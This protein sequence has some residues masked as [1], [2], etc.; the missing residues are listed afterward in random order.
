MPSR[1]ST[2]GSDKQKVQAYFAKLPVSARLRLRELQRAIRAAAPK[3]VIAFSY[4]IPAYRL[5][6]RLLVWYAAFAHHCSLFP[7]TPAIRRQF[8]KELTGYKV[9]KGTVRFPLDTPIPAGLVRRLVK[10]RMAA[11]GPQ[12]RARLNGRGHP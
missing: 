6:G 3:G 7:M 8:A 2:K 12:R 10:A 1:V 11:L 9:A 4:Q 5:D